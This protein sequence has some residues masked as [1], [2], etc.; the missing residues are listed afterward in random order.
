MLVDLVEKAF[1]RHRKGIG[2]VLRL[3]GGEWEIEAQAPDV[4]R[5]DNE[6][7]ATAAKTIVEAFGMMAERGWVTDEIAIRLA[8]KFAGEV[9]SEEEI[10]E[11]L[12][13]AQDESRQGA[14][15]GRTNGTNGRNGSNGGDNGQLQNL[16]T[17]E[18]GSD[19]YGGRV[20][21]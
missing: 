15:D 4:S 12:R 7:M 21:P 19:W 11:I 10:Q 8:F 2:R 13:Q 6:A 20:R 5:A 1:V 18:P 14:E 9:L 17:A 16:A 3:P